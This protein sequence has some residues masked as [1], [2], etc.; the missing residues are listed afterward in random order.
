MPNINKIKEAS[1]RE[2]P[3]KKPV[4]EDT[5][6]APITAPVILAWELIKKNSP[7]TKKIKLNM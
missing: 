3:A 4:L 5:A 6:D 1:I 7:T 2:A